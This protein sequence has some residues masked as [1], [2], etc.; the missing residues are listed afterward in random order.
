VRAKNLAKYLD[1]RRGK[2]DYIMMEF[3]ICTF[4]PMCDRSIR[5]RS[6]GLVGHVVRI[7]ETINAY[8]VLTPP[9]HGSV[10]V[11]IACVIFCNFIPIKFHS[12]LISRNNF[13]VP[14][15]RFKN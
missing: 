8:T 11:G 3:V 14:C 15:E 5:L 6:M 10:R 9:V 12:Q 7:R 2:S 4:H 13:L 1:L